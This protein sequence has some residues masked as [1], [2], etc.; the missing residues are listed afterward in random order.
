VIGIF[1]RLTLDKD[2]GRRQI[3]SEDDWGRE[4][5]HSEA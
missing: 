5:R 2:Y 4:G 3:S 1:E